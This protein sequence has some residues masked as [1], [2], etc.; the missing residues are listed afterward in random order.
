MM[1]TSPKCERTFK[2]SNQS[3]TCT[4][5]VLDDLFSGKPPEL[6]LAFDGILYRVMEWEPNDVG[7]ATKAIVFYK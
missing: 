2:A 1:W 3:H 7:T 5:V 4:K 6:L